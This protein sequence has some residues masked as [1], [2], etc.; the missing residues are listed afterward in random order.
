MVFGE[1]EGV[2]GVKIV[3]QTI[4]VSHIF[5]HVKE[6]ERENQM[7]MLCEIN[8]VCENPT[9]H[10]SRW[11]TMPLNSVSTIEAVTGPDVVLKARE[12]HP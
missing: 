4:T 11:R 5:V 2:V 9:Q 1:G 3:T 6:E 12:R 10:K 8:T 7:M